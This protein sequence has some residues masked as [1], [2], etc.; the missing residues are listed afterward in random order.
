ML[1][2]VTLQRKY[3]GAPTFQNG[4][5]VC[6]IFYSFPGA[7]TFQNGVGVFF[8]KFISGGTH[9]LEWCGGRRPRCPTGGAVERH[10]FSKVLYIVA[11]YVLNMLGH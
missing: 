6:F 8:F 4:V 11:S 5:D 1:Y 2:I 3:T 10:T 9:F 7:L